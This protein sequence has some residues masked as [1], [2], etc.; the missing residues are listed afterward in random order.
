M[1][2]LMAVVSSMVESF[3]HVVRIA[4]CAHA[5][6]WVERS[7]CVGAQGGGA[8]PAQLDVLRFSA[9]AQAQV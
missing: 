9:L 8:R 6:M 4:G 1:G 5:L 7:L 3:I 2:V